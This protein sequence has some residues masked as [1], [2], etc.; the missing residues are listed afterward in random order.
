MGLDRTQK[1]D[2]SQN[3]EKELRDLLDIRLRAQPPYRESVHVS[4]LENGVFR[5]VF[6][7]TRVGRYFQRLSEANMDHYSSGNRRGRGVAGPNKF[8]ERAE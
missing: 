5:K 2:R 8:G 6:L 7:I 1:L 4:C 3:A